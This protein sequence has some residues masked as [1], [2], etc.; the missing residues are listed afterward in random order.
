MNSMAEHHVSFPRAFA[1]GDA[2]EWFKRFEICSKAN[3]WRD[4]TKALKLP[5]LLEGEAL[6]IWLEL[7]EEEQGTY[8]TA[9]K[10]L[11]EKMTPPEFVTLEELEESIKT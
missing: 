7:S 1:N 10:V 2:C 5:T 11:L 9:K 8:E 3:N 4:E 6:A